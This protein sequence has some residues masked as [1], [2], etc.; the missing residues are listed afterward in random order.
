MIESLDSIY[1]LSVEFKDKSVRY[2]RIAHA[3]FVILK[4]FTF[5]A[6][7]LVVP[8]ILKIGLIMLLLIRQLLFAFDGILIENFLEW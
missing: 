1:D 2:P 7:G 6:F 8:L 4:P 3:T 5:R